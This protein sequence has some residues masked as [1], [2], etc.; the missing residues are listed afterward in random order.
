MLLRKISIGV[1]FLC[2]ATT[3]LSQVDLKAKYE[4]EVIYLSG[5]Y[6]FKKNQRYPI[7]NLSSEFQNSQDGLVELNLAKSDSRKAKGFLLIGALAY[8]SGAI[9]LSNNEDVGIGLVV[10]S[11]P[12]NLLSIHF[13]LKANKK[14]NRAVWLR[15]RDILIE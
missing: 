6:Y 12:I 1:V 7:R 10:V 15:N 5:R 14:L 2:I 11:I 9:V 13:S 8:F 4:K 3:A